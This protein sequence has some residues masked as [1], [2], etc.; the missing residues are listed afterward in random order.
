M[1]IGFKTIIIRTTQHVL[2][3]EI[4]GL[5]TGV[6]AIITEVMCDQYK[7]LYNF[8]VDMLALFCCRF[9]IQKNQQLGYSENGADAKSLPTIPASFQVKKSHP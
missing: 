7:S 4:N 3:R 8:I 1:L 2:A 5:F 9:T 6:H